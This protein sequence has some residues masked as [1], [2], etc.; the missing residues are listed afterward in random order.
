MKFQNGCLY[1]IFFAPVIFTWSCSTAPTTNNTNSNR[2]AV[3][4]TNVANTTTTN[5]TPTTTPTPTASPAVAG[6]GSPS[7]AINVYYQAMVT[8][9]EKSFRQ[10]LS[11]ATLSEFSADASAEGEKT[12]VSYWTG[13]TP[14]PKQAFEIRNERVNGD[15]ALL[16][17][18]NSN[19]NQWFLTKLIRENGDWKLDLTNSTLSSLREQQSRK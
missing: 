12:L 14:L 7:A 3:S 19:T 1:F 4:N 17:L 5:A 2:A 8:K 16:E 6:A 11:K 10:V 15:V 9:D 13:Y 18:K